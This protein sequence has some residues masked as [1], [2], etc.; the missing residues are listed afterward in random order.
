L[1]YGLNNGTD[2]R[3]IVNL[4]G[5]D[6][7]LGIY[8]GSVFSVVKSSNSASNRVVLN[9]WNNITFSKNS[10]G[11]DLIVNGVV[12]TGS[13]TSLVSAGYTNSLI[14]GARSISSARYMGLINSVK[15]F[16]SSDLNENN[17]ITYYDF[18]TNPLKNYVCNYD[19]QYVYLSKAGCI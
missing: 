15:L 1:N 14:I 4:A 9:A 7:R 2:I 10:S 16:N 5:T 12:A 11:L 13:S 18:S 17:I 6:V 3:F 8:N 19:N